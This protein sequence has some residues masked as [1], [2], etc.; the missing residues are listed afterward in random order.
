MIP[1]LINVRVSGKELGSGAF[2][3]CGRQ[4]CPWNGSDE[5]PLQASSAKG[6]A[7]LSFVLAAENLEGSWEG[8]NGVVN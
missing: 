6:T 7:F 1:L 2:L 5:A 8:R 3:K 4:P